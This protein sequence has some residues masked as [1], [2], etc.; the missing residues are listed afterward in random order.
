[1]FLK[2]SDAMEAGE[3]AN[4]EHLEMLRKGVDTWNLWRRKNPS[5]IPDPYGAD[6]NGLH[7]E[8]VHFMRVNL[9]EADFTGAYLR[10][11]CFVGAFLH[12]AV[13]NEALVEGANSSGADLSSA[14]MLATNL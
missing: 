11:A 14:M 3:M 4:Q 8:S 5:V 10:G 6:F 13:F 2:G 9:G 1:V 12:G 7:L